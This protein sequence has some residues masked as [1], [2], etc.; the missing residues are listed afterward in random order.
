MVIE[1]H[2]FEHCS[3]FAKNI[4]MSLES[5]GIGTRVKHPQFGEGVIID[6]QLTTCTIYFKSRGEVDMSKEYE[7]IEILTSAS[8][9]DMVSLAEVKKA[10]KQ[11]ILQFGDIND[12][13]ELGDKWL[14]GKLILKPGRSDLKEKEIPIETFFHKIVMLRDRLRV[15]EQRI[16]STKNLNE[17]EKI[18]LQQYLTRIYGSLT[19]FNVLFDEKDDRFIG[20]KSK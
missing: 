17:E 4:L 7:G 20:E 5:A 8:S 2:L 10:L 15:M 9:E 18:N 3:K 1:Y 6:D 16:N 12:K 19:T 14:G 13:V 11:V